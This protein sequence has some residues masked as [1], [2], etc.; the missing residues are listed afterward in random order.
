LTEFGILNIYDDIDDGFDGEKCSGTL[1]GDDELIF[2]G[3]V[4]VDLYVSSSLEPP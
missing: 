3:D 4:H 1:D 2:M